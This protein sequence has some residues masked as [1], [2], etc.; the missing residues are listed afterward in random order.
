MTRKPTLIRKRLAGCLAATGVCLMVLLGGR[1]SLAY[2]AQD[3]EWWHNTW[4]LNEL[5]E[6]TDGTGVTVAVTL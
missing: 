5:H 3:G 1:P 6:V 4:R 2:A